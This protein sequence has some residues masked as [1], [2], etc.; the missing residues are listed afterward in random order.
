MA[1]IMLFEMTLSYDIILPLMLC[2]V[3]A[4]YTAKGLEDRSLYGE[5]LKR[6]AAE[7]PASNAFALTR[8]ADLMKPNPPALLESAHFA[9][10]ARMFLNE[11]VNNLYVTDASGRFL[12]VVSLHDIKPYL[13]EPDLA[14]FVIARDIMRE[15]FPSV[16]PDQPLT[17]ALGRF[18]GITAE[19]LP[20]V[21]AD[22]K[23]IGSLAKGDLLLALVEK[24]KK[25]EAA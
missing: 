8:V 20:V 22:G 15:D 17:A 7:E 16:T 3:I 25:T 23:L 14:E 6:K 13:G 4:Y 2:S 12:G 10:I 9:E 11:R 18:L 24:Q 1:V 21:E 5:V 19:R